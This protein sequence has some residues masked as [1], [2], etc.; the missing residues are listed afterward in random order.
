VLQWGQARDWPASKVVS[1]VCMTVS[2]VV[3]L[4]SL[5]AS[6]TLSGV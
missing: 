6:V 1:S 4:L 5:M 3:V 2:R